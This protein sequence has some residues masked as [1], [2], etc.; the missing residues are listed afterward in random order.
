MII[1]TTC[2]YSPWFVDCQIPNPCS[3][4]SER[5]HAISTVIEKTKNKKE[6]RARACVCFL[7]SGLRSFD[8]GGRAQHVGETRHEPCLHLP[9][10]YRGVT[11]ACQQEIPC[12]G[13]MS[14]FV[15][16]RASE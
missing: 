14:G 6:V 8:A 5:F 13:R 11:R 3:V 2:E 12:M 4:A 15:S 9:H 1:S 16:E 7:F 10:F